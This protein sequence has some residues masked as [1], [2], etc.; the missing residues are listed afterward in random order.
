MRVNL[1]KILSIAAISYSVIFLFVCNKQT[2]ETDN[3]DKAYLETKGITDDKYRQMQVE[4]LLANSGKP[5]LIIDTID[6]EFALKLKGAPVWEYPITLDGDT[7]RAQLSSFIKTFTGK[8]H[9]L[10]RAV[11]SKYLF[12]ASPKTPDSVLSIVGE[13][14]KVNPKLL[15]R[16]IPEKFQIGW[17]DDLKLV[18]RT[19]IEG[20]P[21][22]NLK[23]VLVKLADTIESPFSERSLQVTM[24][25]EAAL[26]LYRIADKGLPTLIILQ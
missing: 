10:L 4:L 25:G 19:D 20:Q 9:K 2:T 16:E 12:E 21:I 11:K 5:Y 18:V 24:Q 14:V 3:K 17:G 26:T 6:N 23:N 22:S 7:A 8:N 1:K 15:Q 13:V